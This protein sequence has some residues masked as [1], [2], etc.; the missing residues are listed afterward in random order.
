MHMQ[1]FITY[2]ILTSAAQ[3]SSTLTFGSIQVRE[4]TVLLSNFCN[5]FLNTQYILLSLCKRTTYSWSV[6]L[7]IE[8]VC[9]LQSHLTIVVTSAILFP[10]YCLRN[11]FERWSNWLKA[12]VHCQTETFQHLSNTQPIFRSQVTCAGQSIL[13]SLLGIIGPRFPFPN[14]W[15]SHL[16]QQTHWSKHLLLLSSSQ[17][18]TT[19]NTSYGGHNLLF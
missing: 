1:I 17:H 2:T 9:N 14:R 16:S 18:R 13:L 3:V 11:Q 19:K 6:F 7:P 5:T 15:Y 12:W 10:F 8:L 4:P